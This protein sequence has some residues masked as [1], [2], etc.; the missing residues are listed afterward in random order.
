MIGVDDVLYSTETDISVLDYAT[1]NSIKKSQFDDLGHQLDTGQSIT[2]DYNDLVKYSHNITITWE[3]ELYAW[4]D[5][6]ISF[7]NDMTDQVVDVSYSCTSDSD[8]KTTASLTLLIPSGNGYWYTNRPYDSDSIVTPQIYKIK[9]KIK[10]EKGTQIERNFGFFLPDNNSYSYDSKSSTYSLQLVNLAYHLTKEGG[11]VIVTALRTYS[12]YFAEPYNHSSSKL[13][14][15]KDCVD[16]HTI[17]DP[18]YGEQEVEE[19]YTYEYGTPEQELIDE[20]KEL[21]KAEQEFL[22]S[23]P[24][25]RIVLF[26]DAQV[27]YP[28]EFERSMKQINTPL[29]ITISG[30]NNDDE[31]SNFVIWSGSEMTRLIYDFAMG[32]AEGLLPSYRLPLAGYQSPDRDAEMVSKSS[33]F[34]NGWRFDGGVDVMT[35]AKTIL[36]DR[37]YEPMVWVDE[38]LQLCVKT[39]PTFSNGFRGCIRYKTYGELVISESISVNEQDFFNVVEVFGK[40][41][42]YY[43]ICN[44]SG[45][46]FGVL[47]NVSSPSPI[48]TVPKVKTIVDNTLESDEDCVNLAEYEYWKASRNNITITIQVADNTI[49]SFSNMSHVVGEQFFEYKLQQGNTIMCLLTKA[50]LSNN[51][52][53]LELKPFNDFSHGYSWTDVEI[54][55]IFHTRIYFNEFIG[56]KYSSGGIDLDSLLNLSTGTRSLNNSGNNSDQNNTRRA[57]ADDSVNTLAQPAIIAYQYMDDSTLRLYISS[58]DIGFGLVKVWANDNNNKSNGLVYVGESSDTDGTDVLPWTASH[59]KTIE[60]LRDGRHIYKVFDYKIRQSSVL[61]FYCQLYNTKYN[62]SN[63]SDIVTIRVDVKS[64]D[65]SRGVYLLDENGDVLTTELSEKLTI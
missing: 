34:P 53:T 30:R 6:S 27:L 24:N 45:S 31:L 49:G 46:S 3:V 62:L 16:K 61:N 9:Q 28:K 32:T 63:Y 36:G 26:G 56:A 18:I 12:Y 43:G 4:N 51:V 40:D 33:I 64:T 59:A 35:L 42:E 22:S 60:E 54:Y 23:L 17:V 20:T 41:S 19:A 37:Y 8:I 48:S 1:N 7:I 21:I 57:K 25:K 55:Q 65:G 47:N 14:A 15:Y 10:S 2:D 13:I 5:G 29:S 50:S 11:G 44:G 38:N 52:W 39:I 58:I